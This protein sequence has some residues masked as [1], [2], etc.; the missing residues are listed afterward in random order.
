MLDD[1]T[2]CEIDTGETTIF[3]RHAGCGPPLRPPGINAMPPVRFA[4][5]TV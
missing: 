1:F 4:D 5:P 3:L 2:G